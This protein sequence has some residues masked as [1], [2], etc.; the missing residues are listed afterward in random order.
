MILVYKGGLLLSGC[1]ANVARARPALLYDVPA[2]DVQLTAG[3]KILRFLDA[4]RLIFFEPL[5]RCFVERVTTSRVHG[6]LRNEQ[7]SWTF[8]LVTWLLYFWTLAVTGNPR[9]NKMHRCTTCSSG[10]TTSKDGASGTSPARSR[11]AAAEYHSRTSR[12]S[13]SLASATARCTTPK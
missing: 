6:V 10:R 5:A 8:L 2:G 4:G 11:A 7:S 1:G 9:A 3:T 13:R 12:K